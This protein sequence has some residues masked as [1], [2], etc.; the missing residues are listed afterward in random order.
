MSGLAFL[1]PGQGSQRVGMGR[2]L[3]DRFPESREVFEEA[4]EALGESLSRLCFEGPEEAL[5]LTRN[6]QPALLAVS[7]AALR[8]LEARGGPV[9]HDRRTQP[10]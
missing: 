5:R 7:V 10:G 6:T 8:A 9:R 3:N 1:F 4:D 2:D